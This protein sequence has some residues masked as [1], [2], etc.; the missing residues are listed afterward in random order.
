MS[1]CS[2]HRPVL[3]LGASPRVSVPMARSLRRHGTPVD[4]ASFQPEEPDIQSRSICGFHRLPPCRLDAVAFTRALLDLVRERHF[5]TILPAG[6]PPLAALRDLYQELSPTVHVGCPSPGGLERVLNKSL[7][8]EAAQKVGIR[9]Q[10]K[11]SEERRVGSR[12]S[13]H[14]CGRR[15]VARIGG[16]LSGRSISECEFSERSHG[17]TGSA[18]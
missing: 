1:E 3:M 18:K 15:S 2:K 12:A 7:T 16:N 6:D 8:L 4:I 17:G 14:K 13:G 5:D 9:C 10:M 11:M